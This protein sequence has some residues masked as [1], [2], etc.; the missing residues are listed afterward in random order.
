MPESIRPDPTVDHFDENNLPE[1]ITPP[2][3]EPI[4]LRQ[5]YDLNPTLRD[6]PLVVSSHDNPG[7]FDV[8]G[9]NGSVYTVV[10]SYDYEGEDQFLGIAFVPN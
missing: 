6:L 10:A 3:G 8:V 1:L 5:L 7:D 9:L 2:V 4:T